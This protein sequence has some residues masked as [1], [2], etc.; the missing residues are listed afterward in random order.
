MD[1]NIQNWKTGYKID[2]VTI[3]DMNNSYRLGAGFEYLPQKKRFIPYFQKLTYRAGIFSGRF[4]TMFNDKEI[5]EYGFT[6]GLGLPLGFMRNHLDISFEY[7]NRG[8]LNNNL[9]KESF[10]QFHFTLTASE[11]WFEKMER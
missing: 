6:L 2:N 5:N 11:L 7:G 9:A 4:N 10:F 3:Q 1:L 8:N